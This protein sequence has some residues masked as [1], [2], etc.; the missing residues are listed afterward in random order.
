MSDS[1]SDSLLREILTRTRR[2]AVVGVSLNP[3]RPSYYVARYLSLK[4]FKVVPVNPG[5]AGE[6]L[7]GQTVVARL[8]DIEGDVDMVDIFRRSEHVPPIVEEA[9]EVFPGLRTIWMQIGVVHEGAAEMAR[10]RGVDVVMN[11]C[12]KIE[13]Q[14]LFGE[15]R[16]GGFNTGVI[17]SKL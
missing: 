10:A 5:H 15:L 16:M 3:V 9:L 13:Y 6:T 7:F 12:P 11:R 1:Y 17:S 4:K 2:V 14:R 8:S